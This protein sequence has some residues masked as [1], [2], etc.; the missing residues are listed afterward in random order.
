MFNNNRVKCELNEL[1]DK[2]DELGMLKDEFDELD[3]SPEQL[4]Q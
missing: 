3:N 1:K 2:L 4:V